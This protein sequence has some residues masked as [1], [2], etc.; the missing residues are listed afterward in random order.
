MKLNEA[1]TRDGFGKGLLELGERDLRVVV[2]GADISESTRV[3]WFQKRFPDRFFS[4]G[5]AEQNGMGVAAGFALAGKIPFFCT[6]GVFASG[7]AWD[8]I[9]T[10]VAYSNLNVKIGGAHGGI[11]VGPD[12]ATH[13]ALE[14]IAIMRVIPRMTLLVPADYEETRK[15][16]IASV[17]QVEGPCYIRFGRAPTP[18]FI[19][20]QSPFRVGKADLLREGRDV[21]IIGCGPILYGALEAA[22]KLHQQGIE[23]RILNMHTVKPIDREAI[24]TA[25]RDTGAILTLEEHQVNGGMGSAVAETVSQRCPV[26]MAIMGVPDRFGESGEPTQLIRH[27][28]LSPRHIIGQ[29]KKLLDF[30]G[31]M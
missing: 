11:S 22:K 5:I 20:P 14:E 1:P 6:Y 25:A 17:E 13:Q 4:V 21:T 9:R 26:P 16:T 8:Q 23:C 19:D 29:V 31:L 7:R 27:F 24:L 10:T 15:A 3:H 30:K 2:I 28:G 12:G 18:V